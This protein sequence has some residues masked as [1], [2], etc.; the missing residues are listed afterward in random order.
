MNQPAM[1]RLTPGLRDA[2]T[3][4][5]VT[6]DAAASAP[7]LAAL[8]SC[9]LDVR[10]VPA[11]S[12][13]AGLLILA[14]GL[15]EQRGSLYPSILESLKGAARDFEQAGGTLILLQDTGGTF[16]PGDQRAWLGGLTGLART[17]A[18]EFPKA[19][20][21]LIDLDTSGLG[22]DLA[23]ARLIE[24]L[25]SGGTAPVVGLSARGRFVPQDNSLILPANRPG[26]L[27]SADVL[28]V[29]GGAR[30]VTADCIIE[31]ARRT[32]ARFALLGRSALRDWPEGL[33]ETRD[34]RALRGALARQAAASGEKL[35]P[36]D[37]NARARA[38]LSGAEIRD[39]LDAIRTAGG[40]A[41]YIPADVADRSALARAIAEAEARLGPI[42]GLVHG[43]GVLADKLIREK[44]PEQL[45]RVFGPKIDGLDALLSELDTSRLKTIAFFSSVAA[46]YGN[47]GQSDYAMANELLNRMAWCLKASHPETM[48]TSINWGPW[49]GGM[50]D[51]GLRAKFA[52]MGVALISRQAGANAFADAVLA[53]A[54]CPV[55][56]VAGAEI[57]H[58]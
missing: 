25:L 35:K 22:P 21:R 39:T 48:V 2:G 3:V 28:L 38:L 7:Y 41:I 31:L 10:A 27:S 24:E 6:A 29:T 55:E 50:V 43:A 46:R 54:A 8:A 58:G 52:E 14:Q 44:T 30:G 18:R 34:E 32:G 57:A 11:P 17:A 51:D 9:G 12:G 19:T 37:L 40:D 33:E 36:A 1:G 53:G 42:T 20:V 56:I 47:A 23:A 13:K 15:T 49:D 26:L 45:A 16:Q 4:E 5:F